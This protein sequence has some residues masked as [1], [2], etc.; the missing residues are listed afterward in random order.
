MD[1]FFIVTG[2]PGS[3]KSTL[4]AALAGQGVPHMP[5][6][7]R[8]IIR[9]QQAIG[10]SALPWDDRDAYAEQMLWHDMRSY[11]EALALDGPVLFDRGIPDIIGYRELSG[12]ACPPHL[13]MAAESLRYHGTVFV[14]PP[15]REIYARDS[16]RLQDWAEAVATHDVMIRVYER[17]GYRPLPLPLGPVAE[18]AA[19]VR[20][21]LRTAPATDTAGMEGACR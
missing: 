11:E 3:G 16:E 1:R 2:G 10:G 21:Y 20:D 13:L 19:F 12:L 14:A 17:F 6:A 4:L 18:R 7:G 5:E 8:A 9:E 15:W